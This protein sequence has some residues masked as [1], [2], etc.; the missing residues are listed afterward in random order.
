MARWW[1]KSASH[2]APH[3]RISSG[4]RKSGRQRGQEGKAYP[5]HCGVVTESR[6]TEDDGSNPASLHPVLRRTCTNLRESWPRSDWRVHF[7]PS[8]KREA[9]C[10]RVADNPTPRHAGGYQIFLPVSLHR[11]GKVWGFA[12]AKCGSLL[13]SDDCSKIHSASE[14]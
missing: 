1:L 10:S 14:L 8:L 4:R 11:T 13:V 12:V 9:A 2:T 3:L 5:T 6:R 7:R